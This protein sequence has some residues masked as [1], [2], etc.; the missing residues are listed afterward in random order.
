MNGTS[1]ARMIVSTPMM[2][3]PEECF[4]GGWCAG[5]DQKPN[6]RPK[7]QRANP[8]E[9]LADGPDRSAQRPAQRQA[10]LPGYGAAETPDLKSAAE[11][12][13]R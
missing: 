4:V 7:Q 13:S 8:P 12:V 5:A 10:Y 3:V 6:R 9:Q 1:P 11:S 2:I